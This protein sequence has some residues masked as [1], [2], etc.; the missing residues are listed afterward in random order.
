MNIGKYLKQIYHSFADIPTIPLELKN[1]Q[2]PMVLH[3]SDTPVS[4]H[5]FIYKVIEELK[6]NYLIHTGDLVDNV[7]M[8][9]N[10]HLLYYYEERAAAFIH[11][12][13][14]LPLE[15]IFLV[16]GN[17]DNIEIIKNYS[18]RI[19]LLQEGK[20]ITLENRVF[21]V[22]HHPWKLSSHAEY[23]LYGHN[24][25]NIPQID[26]Q[27]F[28]NGLNKMHVILLHSNEIVSLAYPYGINHDRR[29][30]ANKLFRKGGF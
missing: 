3:I 20:N 28:L 27:V 5:P 16:A 2:E 6:P 11:Q 18:Q 23:Y 25:E 8:E 7:K 21:N 19:I 10:P 15:K 12:L 22:A 26:N 30:Y 9:F 1:I 29:M 24:F 4:S 14:Q 13:E 17:H